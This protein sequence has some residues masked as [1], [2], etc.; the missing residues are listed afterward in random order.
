MSRPAS[1]PGIPLLTEVIVS[2]EVPAP[3]GAIPAAQAAAG[4]P[5]AEALEAQAIAT[6]N[7]EQWTRLERRIRE[8]ILRQI[9]ARTDAMLEQ[10][11]RDTL[12]DVLQTAVQTLADEIR[13][14]LR[15][16]LED[17]VTRAVSQEIARLQSTPK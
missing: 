2:D 5:G 9:L 11:V 8:R 15:Q 3:A 10:R 13:G 16:G 7:D 12:A 17:I 4:E 1:D 14:S 6:W